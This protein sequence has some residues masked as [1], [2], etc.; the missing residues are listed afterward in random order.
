[1]NPRIAK[2]YSRCG[3]SE[4]STPQPR[5]SFVWHLL[6]F[7]LRVVLGALLVWASLSVLVILI[8]MLLQ[9]AEVQEGLIVLGFL[10][11]G[12]WSLWAILPQWLQR[13]I[14]RLI[15]GKDTKHDR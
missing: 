1:M 7:V 10:L 14:R 4:L 5:V 2:T 9:R 6:A 8:P 13:L 11:I 3:S 15:R 12:L